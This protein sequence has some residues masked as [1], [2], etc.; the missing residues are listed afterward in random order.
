MTALLLNHRPPLLLVVDDDEVVRSML[1]ENLA[2]E[3]YQIA[4]AKNGEA[5]L[6]VYQQIQPDMVL[7]DGIMPV[8]DGF[9]CC[10]KLQELPG[11]PQTP[12]LIRR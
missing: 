11:G 7:L 1:V 9:E 2:Q 3:G 5:A 4:Q 6:V 8:M 12:V 10:L